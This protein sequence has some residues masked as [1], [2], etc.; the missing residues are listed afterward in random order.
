MS[1]KAANRWLKLSSFWIRTLLGIAILAVG[2]GIAYSLYATKPELP[3]RDGNDSAVIVVGTIPA[4]RADVDRVWSGYGTARSM[5]AVNLAAQ[6]AGRIAER[7][8][9]VEPGNR[10]AAGELLAQ[11]EQTDYL[12]R[13]RAA[14]QFVA[15][16]LADLEALKIDEA[17]WEEQLQ[18]AEDQAAIERRELS[19]AYAALER[20]AATTSEIDR[21]TKAL[22]VLEVQVSTIRQQF[23]RVPSQRATLEATLDRVRADAEVASQN[24]LRTGITAPFDGVLESVSV[25]TDEYVNIGSPIARVVDIA[26]IEVP[27]KVPASALGYVRVGDV[28]TL[29]PD[30]PATHSWTGTVGRISPEIDPGTR[31]ITVFIEVSQNPEAFQRESHDST[32]LL[33]P[34]QFVACTINGAPETDRLIVPRRAVQDGRLFIA[35]PND[36]N[37]WTAR[38]ADVRAL[39]HTTGSYPDIDPAE[40][41]WTVL[42]TNDIPDNAHIIVTNL[43]VMIDGK[44]VNTASRAADNTDQPATTSSGDSR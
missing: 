37:L 21:R 28:A 41:Q 19:Q 29:R 15:Q 5:N 6:V 10:V 1:S 26:H 31:S 3:P 44:V 39:F 34:G 43:D 7:P 30:G 25:E 23:Q 24:L 22:R 32:T 18:I 9:G 8:D 11:I 13:A 36:R 4:T 33:L 38:K 27:L 2:G 20:G 40:Q 16:A 35:L 14:E 42:D 17:A 12:A